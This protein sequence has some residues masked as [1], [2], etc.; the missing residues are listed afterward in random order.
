[1]ESFHQTFLSERDPG[2][3]RP[4]RIYRIPFRS[5]TGT[6]CERRCPTP[7][8]PLHPVIIGGDRDSK[9]GLLGGAEGGKTPSRGGMHLRVLEQP[10]T[11]RSC[12]ASPTHQLAMPSFPTSSGTGVLG[13]SAASA[14]SSDESPSGSSGSAGVSS[15]A[16]LS[17]RNKSTSPASS[18]STNTG[19]SSGSG[20]IAGMMLAAAGGKISPSKSNIRNRNRTN[21]LTVE[22]NSASHL[23]HLKNHLPHFNHHKI[24]HPLQ[25]HSTYK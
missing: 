21:S 5:L 1:M 9:D 16:I 23:K 24:R 14:G 6:S 18:R 15:A 3:T 7:T 10:Y 25:H 2:A 20:G 4:Y 17:G 12:T 11:S 19:S 13:S 22:M 8:T